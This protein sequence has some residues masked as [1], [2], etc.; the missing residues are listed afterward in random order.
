MDSQWPSVAVRGAA[1]T[2]APVVEY[3][4]L[5]QVTIGWHHDCALVSEMV[6]H[7]KSF[8]GE[9]DLCPPDLVS[10]GMVKLEGAS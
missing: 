8:S 3:N 6:Q 1:V 9:R 2:C 7:L 5:R 4:V 10:A